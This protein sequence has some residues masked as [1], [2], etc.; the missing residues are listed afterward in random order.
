VN[1]P[2]PFGAIPTLAPC[3]ATLLACAHAPED[4]ATL[5]FAGVIGSAWESRGV[6]ELPLLGIDADVTRRLV[7][8]YFPGAPTL[9]GIPW[10]ALAAVASD[11]SRDDE[12]EDLLQLLLDHRTRDDEET[13]WVAHAVATAC[14][15]ENH[16]WQDMGLPSRTVLSKLLEGYFTPLFRKNTGDMKWKKFFYK[17][18]CDRAELFICKSPSCGIC[19]D[20]QRCFGPED[21]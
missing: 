3:S 8:R 16:L 7:E 11:F 5:A 19:I 6:E 9:L 1:G 18:L 21:K 13:R 12:I 17:Q 4:L 15:G 10:D 14:M 2:A 20:Y